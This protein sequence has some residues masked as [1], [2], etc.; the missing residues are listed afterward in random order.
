MAWWSYALIAAVA[1]SATTIL[2]KVDV[3]DVPS[4]LATAIRTVVILVFAWGVVF[5][6]RKP[7]A[8][9]LLA[10]KNTPHVQ[11]VF[12]CGCDT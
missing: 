5:A 10:A 1:A 7:S 4:N 6:A 9:G 11:A 3:K 8:T 2:A 12:G